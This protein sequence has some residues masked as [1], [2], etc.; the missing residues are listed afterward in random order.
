MSRYWYPALTISLLFHALLLTRTDTLFKG[1]PKAAI[2]LNK[3]KEIKEI[4]MTPQKIERIK[5]EQIKTIPGEKPLPYIDNITNRLIESD[6]KFSSLKKPQIFEKNTK[7]VVFAE[8]LPKD[9]SLKKN[10][11]YMNYYRFIREKIK[12]TTYNNYNRSS[13]GEIIVSFRI[14]NDGTLDSIRF[15]SK[16]TND[17]FLR[18]ITVRSLKESSPFPA[19]PTELNKYPYLQFSVSIYFKNN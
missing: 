2:I 11:A 19:F 18:A 10:P 12:T 4:K 8:V 9:T 17:K 16:S 13:G 14:L 1:S 3:K 5:K 7:E 15:D 6:K